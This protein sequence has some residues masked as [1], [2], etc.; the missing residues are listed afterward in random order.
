[1]AVLLHRLH[2]HTLRAAERADRAKSAFTNAV[3][4]GPARNA[5]KLAAWSIVTLRPSCGWNVSV[6]G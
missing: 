4:N 1:M 6:G 3:V 5:E 2:E